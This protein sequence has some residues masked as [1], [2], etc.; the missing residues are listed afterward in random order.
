MGRI[1][2]GLGSQT[3]LCRTAISAQKAAEVLAHEVLPMLETHRA[4]WH[5]CLQFWSF[6][7]GSFFFWGYCENVFCYMLLNTQRLGKKHFSSALWRLK[8]S[9]FSSRLWSLQRVDESCL[10]TCSDTASDTAS[11]GRTGT[12]WRK[13]APLLHGT[14]QEQGRCAC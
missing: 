13:Q 2:D 11:L 12:G 10:G 14:A 4:I 1:Q 8:L 6:S 5:S 7:E 9:A 3:L